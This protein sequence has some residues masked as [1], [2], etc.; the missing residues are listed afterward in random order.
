MLEKPVLGD[1]TLQL[2]MA[3]VPHAL[4]DPSL[5]RPRLYTF[6]LQRRRKAFGDGT[7]H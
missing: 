1:G 7:S 5:L 3:I 4:I 2:A 6:R